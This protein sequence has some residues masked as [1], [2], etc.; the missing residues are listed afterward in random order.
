MIVTEPQ[1]TLRETLENG[2]QMAMV[3]AWVCIGDAS[4]DGLRGIIG[5]DRITRDDAELHVFGCPRFLTRRILRA[6]GEVMFSGYDVKRITAHMRASNTPLHRVAERLGFVRE[7]QIRRYYG[8]E[9]AVIYGLLRED[10][11]HG[12]QQTP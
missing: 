3:G 10:Y 9:D 7:G 5:F 2:L 1:L 6:A 4:D 11:P 8:E 12:F